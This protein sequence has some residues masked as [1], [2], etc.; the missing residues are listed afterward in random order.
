MRTPLLKAVFMILAAPLA[1]G[2]DWSPRLAADYLD[3]R[4]KEWFAWPAAKAPGGTCI[5]CHTGMTY[6]LSRPALR[7]ALGDDALIETVPKRGYR[8]NP[9]V[10]RPAEAAVVPVIPVRHHWWIWAV[11]AA[12]VAGAAWI[13]WSAMAARPGARRWFAL[14]E[15][16]RIEGR[17]REAVPL[18]A[19]AIELDPEFALAE[20]RLADTYDALRE[21]TARRAHALRAYALRGRANALVLSATQS[22]DVRVV[23]W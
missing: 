17:F 5:S 14:A 10:Q 11:A 19:R 15:T 20:S 7:K 6:L 13:S 1:Y 21:P 4:Q 9:P 3:G 12:L 8:L 16:S 2:G 18:Y 22:A 23:P